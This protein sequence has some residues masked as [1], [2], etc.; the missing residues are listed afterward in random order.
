M[1][2]SITISV[3]DDLAIEM[4]DYKTTQEIKD[5]LKGVLA[6]LVREARQKVAEDSKPA[7]LPVDDSGLSI[8]IN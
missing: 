4:L 6:S 8:I 3:P 5:M 1:A 2:K 7:V